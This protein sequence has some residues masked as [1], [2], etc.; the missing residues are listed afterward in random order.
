MTR[1]EGRETRSIE[2][3]V[4]VAGTPEEVWR[5]IATGPGVSSWYVPHQ[6]EEA[7]G[8][9]VSL[10]FGPG[11]DVEGVVSAWEPPRRIVLENEG[12]G[13]AFEF[14]VEARGSGKCVVRLVNSGFG[15]GEDWDAQYD[16]MTEGWG[17]FL[18]NLRLH[19]EHFA[20]QE[21]S[22]ALPMAIWTD[23]RS[24]AWERFK[25]TLGLPANP[26]PG[27]RIE[28]TGAGAPS[29][30]GTVGSVGTYHWCLEMDTPAP[31]TAFFAAEGTD[32]QVAVS[33]WSYSYGP[34]AS[35]MAAEAEADWRRWLEDHSTDSNE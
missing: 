35:A 24:G 6:I 14:T 34:D 2:R 28:V 4:E 17:I 21:A 25:A 12:P 1:D 19:L 10:T 9:K 29:M 11:M 23:T 16:G 3:E 22:A 32:G 30:A 33:V 26:A 13:L 15:T 18:E 27:D 8:G 7:E 31:G 20:G 5:A